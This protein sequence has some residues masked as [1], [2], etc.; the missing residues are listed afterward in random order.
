MTVAPWLTMGVTG[1]LAAAGL[2]AVAAASLG[3]Q[4]PAPAPLPSLPSRL[5]DSRLGPPMPQPFPAA[6]DRLVRSERR[7]LQT[8]DGDLQLVLLQA[9]VRGPEQRSVPALTKDTPLQ[10]SG[11]RPRR[12]GSDRVLIGRLGDRPALQT[13]VTP[14]GAA[15]SRQ[16]LSRLAPDAR[17]PSLAALV[18]L[19][20]QPVPGCLLVSLR[21]ESQRQAAAI[22]D[23]PAVHLIQAWTLLSPVL[24]PEASSSSR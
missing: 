5:G 16:D 7:Q 4:L 15:V 18:G 24:I 19:A 9:V 13:C 10:L 1:G 17:L 2:V 12:L 3:P 20:P 11:A 22:G 8:P 6:A 21:A 23:D 14:G